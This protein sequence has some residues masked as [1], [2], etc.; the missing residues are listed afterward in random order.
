SFQPALRL[1]A[2][3]E[4]AVGRI[5]AAL[6]FSSNLIWLYARDLDFDRSRRWEKVLAPYN[7]RKASDRQRVSGGAGRS[8]HRKAGRTQKCIHLHHDKKRDSFR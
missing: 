3:L 2:F 1:T 5:G 7:R 6:L 8:P 4:S